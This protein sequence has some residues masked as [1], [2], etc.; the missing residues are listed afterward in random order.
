[1]RFSEVSAGRVR[2]EPLR[3]VSVQ[4]PK[5]RAMSCAK[6]LYTEIGFDVEIEDGLLSIECGRVIAPHVQGILERKCGVIAFNEWDL[7]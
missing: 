1:M 4:L 3:R 2:R 5:A 7:P 6:A